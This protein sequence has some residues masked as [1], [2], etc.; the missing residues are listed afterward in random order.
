MASLLFKIPSLLLSYAIGTKL[1]YSDAFCS[2]STSLRNARDTEV[3]F[4][5]GENWSCLE[6]VDDVM[7]GRLHHG[8]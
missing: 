8:S 1:S 2:E 4:V 6:P 7:V 3:F 5:D